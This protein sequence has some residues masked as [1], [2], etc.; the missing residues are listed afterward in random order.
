MR[1]GEKYWTYFIDECSDFW[2][3]HEAIFRGDFVD[4]T[5]VSEGR[6]YSSK[7]EAEHA[8]ERANAK[9]RANQ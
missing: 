9:R 6:V 3:I 1:Q 4:N 8:A 7:S 2:Q 5:R